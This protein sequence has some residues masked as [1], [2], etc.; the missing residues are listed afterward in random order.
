MQSKAAGNAVERGEEARLQKRERSGAR[1]EHRSKMDAEARLE[2]ERRAPR[3]QGRQDGYA[4]SPETTRAAP[5][6]D[7]AKNSATKQNEARLTELPIV[8]KRMPM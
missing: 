5:N 7:A 1:Q 2:L 4:A 3:E 6:R 8:S